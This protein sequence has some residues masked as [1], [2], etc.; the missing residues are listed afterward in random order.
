MSTDT[1]LVMTPRDDFRY[2]TWP[3]ATHRTIGFDAEPYD[4]ATIPE[5]VIVQDLMN[6]LPAFGFS[7]FPQYLWLEPDS[8]RPIEPGGPTIGIMVDTNTYGPF[9]RKSL[10]YFAA[11]LPNGT[12]TGILRHRLMRLNSTVACTR[13]NS[14]A[15]PSTCSG[16]DPW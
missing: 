16:D 2:S 12:T 15:F 5:D 14:S 7:E 13:V 4:M 10:T 8:V 6:D 1:V 9:S 11:A 3:Q